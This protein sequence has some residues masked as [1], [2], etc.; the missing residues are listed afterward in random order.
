MAE[1]FLK[2]FDSDWEVSSAGTNPSAQ[3][4]PLAI[5]VMD[6][7]GIDISSYTPKSVDR[8]LDQRFDYVIT[9][10]DHAR[11]TCPVFTGQVEHHLHLGFEDPAEAEGSNEE[12]LAV[13]RRIRDEILEEFEKFYNGLNQ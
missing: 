3:V 1:A 13:F 10:C 11:E 2:S 6:E 8:F 9:V 12:K 7:S 5:Q 4:H